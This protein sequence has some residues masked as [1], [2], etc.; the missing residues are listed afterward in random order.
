MTWGG[1]SQLSEGRRTGSYTLSEAGNNVY[2]LT[3]DGLVVF[4]E[5]TSEDL[6]LNANQG[7]TPF[8][9]FEP[10]TALPRGGDVVFANESV[11][12]FIDASRRLQAIDLEVLNG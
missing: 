8:A 4:D 1:W 6:L 10:F 9:A 12:L 2:Q 3:K 11:V 5:L 7:F